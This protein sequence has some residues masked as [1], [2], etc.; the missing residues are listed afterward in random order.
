M[1]Q[2]LRRE[3]KEEVTPSCLLPLLHSDPQ[4]AGCWPHLGEG[5]VSTEPQAQ[6]LI[7]SRNIPQIRPEMM[8]HLGPRDL[9]R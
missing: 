3:E 8:L 2:L 5:S 4:Q 7:P 9:S 6:L 1:S